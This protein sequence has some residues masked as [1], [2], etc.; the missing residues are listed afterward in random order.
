MRV[1]TNRAEKDYSANAINGRMLYRFPRKTGSRIFGSWKHIRRQDAHEERFDDREVV[2]KLHNSDQSLTQ[3]I[4]ARAHHLAES[5]QVLS[6]MQ[7]TQG[8]LSSLRW[9]ILGLAVLTGFSLVNSAL[10]FSHPNINVLGLLAAVLFVNLSCSYCG[11]SAWFGD[12]R[13]RA[14]LRGRVLAL[15]SWMQKTFRPEKSKRE[16]QQA[17]RKH[18][19]KLVSG[20]ATSWLIATV[21][22]SMDTL[23]L[24]DDLDC[25]SHA[26]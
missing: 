13:G 24:A 19:A 17:A 26:Y 3:K 15:F 10:M 9:I 12:R 8:A 11:A 2:A 23:V 14:E 7:S 1:R 5:R 6:A 25:C 21:V 4:V 22:E 20:A 18:V 16:K